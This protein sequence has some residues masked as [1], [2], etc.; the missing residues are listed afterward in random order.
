MPVCLVVKVLWRVK[1]DSS[2]PGSVLT[3]PSDVWLE[4]PPVPPA[5][6]CFCN[7]VSPYPTARLHRTITCGAVIFNTDRGNMMIAPMELPLNQGRGSPTYYS[8]Y[9]EEFPALL[10]M[11]VRDKPGSTIAGLTCP[12]SRVIFAFA[13]AGFLARAITGMAQ[14]RISVSFRNGIY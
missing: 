14:G 4:T 10:A 9:C 2:T 3:K 12:S 5:H 8:R 7:V 1:T 11:S 6:C 13:I